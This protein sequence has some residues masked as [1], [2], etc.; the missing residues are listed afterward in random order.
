MQFRYPAYNENVEALEWL[1]KCFT[2]LRTG[3][4]CIGSQEKMDNP[5]LLSLECQWL[6]GDMI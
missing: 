5:G 6:K 1:W 3:L 4:G 2:G